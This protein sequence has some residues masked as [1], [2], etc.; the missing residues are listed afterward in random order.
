MKIL[1][2]GGGTGGHFYPII[3][4]AEALHRLADKEH[5]IDLSLFYVSDDPYNKDLL[6]INRMKYVEIK[7]GKKRTYFS[8][9]NFTD[10]FKIFFACINATIR[11]FMIYPDVVFGKGG[12][13]SFPMMFAA[14]LLRIPVV[15]HESDISLGRVNK[16]IANYAEKIAISYPETAASIAHADTRAALTGIPVRQ[17]MLEIPTENGYELF[18]LEQNIKTIFVI[19]GSQGSEKI[20]DHI[21]DIMPKLVEKYQVIHQ[22]GNDNLEWMKKRAQGVLSGNQFASR[23]KPFGYLDSKTLRIAADVAAI[24][25]SRAGST[26]F[27]IAPTSAAQNAARFICPR[28]KAI[29][30]YAKKID[31]KTPPESPSM[32]SMTPEAYRNKDTAMN[33]G[34]MSQPISKF[35]PN[36]FE[37]AE[38]SNFS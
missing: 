38:T 5:V 28:L 10:L 27:E 31:A 35:G 17:N 18:H 16:W 29:N 2:T 6:A 20:N 30:A 22:T 34:I 15:I 8:F 21:L 13:A 37:I 26:I 9:S 14:K 19:G 12:Y 3:A 11:L 23:Y 1:F 33:N 7:T 4:I 32:P 24:V 36:G 25:I